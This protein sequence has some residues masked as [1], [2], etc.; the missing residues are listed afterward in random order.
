MAT[1]EEFKKFYQNNP[2]YFCAASEG[3]THG[4]L[5]PSHVRIHTYVRSL[6]GKTIGDFGCGSG[7]DIERMYAPGNTYIGLDVSEGALTEAR[8]R[9]S[10]PGVTYQQID[11]EKPSPL[12]DASFD[13]LT[14]FFVFEHVL[15]PT[16][17]LREMIRLLRPDGELFLITPNYGSPLKSAP[18]FG[19]PSK[20]KLVRKTLRIMK[21]MGR[22][23]L[24]P[25]APL[26]LKMIPLSAMD[27]SSTWASDMDATNEPWSWE[28]AAYLK[29]H[30]MRTE[31]IYWEPVERRELKTKPEKI[32][33]PLRQLPLI[34]HL[35]A[36][37]VIHATK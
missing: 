24:S 8:K 32:L 26:D 17:T 2:D 12:P 30:G 34:R 28:I 1:K 3:N 27:L 21:T 13:V 5:F 14:S 7:H 18:P 10:P 4:G 11:F 37:C 29:S 35:G 15:N 16:H 36:S 19:P 33:W 20:K 22:R 25:Q 31:Q 23:I 9:F 6:Q